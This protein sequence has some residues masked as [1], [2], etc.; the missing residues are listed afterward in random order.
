MK[1]R[2]IC[3]KHKKRVIIVTVSLAAV[4]LIGGGV[5]VYCLRK[6]GSADL[7]FMQQG[8][9][10]GG[11]STGENMVSSYGITS[12]GMTQE[13]FEV[14]GLETKLL[15]EEVYVSSEEEVSQ[16][17]A[18]LKLSEDTVEEA[19]KELERYLREADL[20]YRAG[21]ITCEQGKITAE[22]NRD[23]AVLEGKQA[24]EVY[25]DT[26][27]GLESAVEKAKEELEEARKK[28]AEY[29]AAVDGDTFYED[30]KVGAYKDLYD[31]NLKLL[32]E[33]MSEWGVGWS[34]VVTSGGSA[35]PGSTTQEN[36]MPVNAAGYESSA[37][38]ENS[39]KINL[40]TVSGG[41]SNVSGNSS[42]TYVSV[43]KRLYS[44][45]EQNLKDYE[46]AQS[47]Y[48]DART[49][50]GFE[51][52]TLELNLPSLEKALTQAQ[53]NYETKKLEARLACETS[54]A[55]AERAERD[56]ETAIQKAEADLE[57]LKDT[58][59]DAEENLALFESSVGDG[60]YYAGGSGTVMRTM[61]R[62]DQYL[63]S[64]SVIFI[65]SNPGKITVT[66]SVDQ[67]DISKIAVGDNAYIQSSEYGEFR[68]TV[69]QI[70][71]VS[72]SDSRTSVIYQVTVSVTGVSEN[73]PANQT[74][75]VIFG[76]GGAADE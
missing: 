67:S 75:T 37:L 26:V 45:L 4:L 17:T 74:V 60:Y 42:N 46:Q 8:I 57:E 12:V 18:I 41:D 22:Y 31:E 27:A 5:M 51:L 43:L 1:I 15:V 9:A 36:T 40:S 58:K 73:L 71:P 38:S 32:T 35:V 3:R 70:N 13:S 39:Q 6:N 50:T 59:E 20:A 34:Q 33:K 62:A 2:E 14:E 44:V 61:L 48:E 64:D 16:G 28:I 10:V 65:Y 53:E 76:L 19:R 69:T 49:N 24:E 56:Y 66:A 23:A 7:P 47:D 30:F 21:I 52:Q 11:M 54:L 25:Q 55:S 63:T 72:S 29:K 68:G